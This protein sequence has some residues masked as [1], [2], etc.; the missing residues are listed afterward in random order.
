MSC[1]WR[2]NLK[3][4]KNQETAIRTLLTQELP[5]DKVGPRLRHAIRRALAS[6]NPVRMLSTAQILVSDLFRQG[7]ML[8]VAIEGQANGTLR[9]GLL[10][11]STQLIDLSVLGKDFNPL[12]FSLPTEPS[13]QPEKNPEF[14]RDLASWTD[15]SGMLGAM[16]QAQDM[17][18]GF[19]QAGET[20]AILTSVLK[21]LARFTPQFDLFVLLHEDE[22]LPEGQSRIFTVDTSDLASGW[23]AVRETGHS[24]WIPSP[25]E[26]P[27][28][29]GDFGQNPDGTDVFCS[30]VA[31]PLLK[32]ED[33]EDPQNSNEELG[34]LFVVAHEEWDR[35]P[36]L[37]LAKRLS[38]F[39][40]VRWQH[41]REVN[42]RIHTDSLTR[43]NNRAFFDNQFTLE[44]ERSRRSSQ[45]LSLVICDIDHFKN[46]NDRY[47]HHN[48]DRVLTMVAR[49]LREELRRIDHV[50]RIGGEEFALILPDTSHEAARE[51]MERLVNS[52][53]TEEVLHDGKMIEL[54][55][56]FSY[57]AVTFPDAGTD[58]F[59]LYRKAD[60]MLFL[61]K[62]LG[63]NQCHFWSS[64]GDHIQLLPTASQ[65]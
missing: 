16:E 43:V 54:E 41:Q 15:F 49:R 3:K 8:R 57:G 58:A 29:I 6:G 65:D 2:E 51:V 39:V 50:C 17:E 61:S 42:Q 9:Y 40:T 45:P 5:L 38:Q 34:L 20:G 28:F 62:D 11:G 19:P 32:P 55:V 1:N 63:R 7:I 37:R 12:V 24:A 44:L 64:E 14:S 60:A 48:G 53:F 35:N 22:I 36:L 52:A 47:L 46:I 56:T 25:E 10:R 33:F 13:S 30:A 31:V 59:E 23:L 26:L 21:L 18:V 27:R 4:M